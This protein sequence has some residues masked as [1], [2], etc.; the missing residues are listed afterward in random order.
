M[1]KQAGRLA[2]LKV[3]A[4][5]IAGVRV[6]NINWNGSA[7][8]TTDRNDGGFQTFLEGVL[9]TDTLEITVEGLEEDGVLRKAALQADQ[10]GKFLSGAVF[11]FPNGDRITGN[12]VLTTYTEGQPYDN[13]T[14]FN[15]TLV[16]N[17]AHEFTGAN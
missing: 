1:T 12:F 4:T 8:D 14:T 17:G 15:A 16:R 9:A 6:L 5:T 13:A 10:A 2:T 7:L 3:G 11:A